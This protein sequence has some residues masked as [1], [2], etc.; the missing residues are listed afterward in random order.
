MSRP[1]F[2]VLAYLAA[3]IVLGA[4][5]A[6]PLYWVGKWL[7]GMIVSFKQEETP[8]LGWIGQK[9]AAH[10]FDSY[11]NRAFLVSALGLLWP[12]LK[13]MKLGKGSLGLEKNSYWIRDW[14]SGFL[15]AGGF[16]AGLAALLCG[17]GAYELVSEVKWGK[18]IPVALLTMAAVS[19]LE[20][21]VFRGIFL[22]VA[23]R[24]SHK[25]VAVVLVSALFS[26]LHLMRAPDMD[27]QEPAVAARAK[28]T[29]RSKNWAYIMNQQ[30][31]NPASAD[32]LT[33]RSM[34]EFAASRISWRSGA[35][36]MGLIFQKNFEPTRFVSVFLT[37]FAIG[38]ILARSRI[39][40]NSLWMPFG[41]HGG[42]VFA[43]AIFAGMTDATQALH[44]GAYTLKTVGAAIPWIG[45]NLKVG[46][47]PLG[48]LLVTALAQEWWL[49]RPRKPEPN[50]NL[51]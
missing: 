35:D 41:L 49:R 21:W 5:L 4:I 38:V 33:D 50:G 51:G 2:K 19:L 42:W 16:L 6:P 17:L 46:L 37:L 9:L 31:L 24:A 47:L 8:L 28:S 44:A 45:D 30:R 14:W 34:Q 23:L 1:Q 11:F 25:V 22:G 43:N 48:T 20:E 40:T 12:F 26:I 27:P 32:W 10:Q 7:A 3:V 29:L 36:L 15:L 39:A 18:I 13:W